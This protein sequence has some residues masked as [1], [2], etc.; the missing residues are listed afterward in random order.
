[1]STSRLGRL[2]LVGAILGTAE[3]FPVVAQDGLPQERAIESNQANAWL[4]SLESQLRAQ[5]GAA[6]GVRGLR[7]GDP[8]SGAAESRG[9]GPKP[10]RRHGPFAAGAGSPRAPGGGDRAAAAGAEAGPGGGRQALRDPQCPATD[11]LRFRRPD[12][13]RSRLQPR[14]CDAGRRASPCLFGHAALRSGMRRGAWARGAGRDMEPPAR[15]RELIC[16][17]GSGSAPKANAWKRSRSGVINRGTYWGA[18]AESMPP[19]RGGGVCPRGERHLA[20]SGPPGPARGSG[21]TGDQAEERAFV[22]ATS[23]RSRCA[24]RRS[25]AVWRRGPGRGRARRSLPQ[26]GAERGGSPT[27]RL[28]RGAEPRPQQQLNQAPPEPRDR[29]ATPPLEVDVVRRVRRG[30]PGQAGSVEDSAPT[31]EAADGHQPREGR[32]GTKPWPAASQPAPPGAWAVRR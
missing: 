16:C 9:S 26:R 20:R 19:G 11:R 7:G 25:L 4:S 31:A 6:A 24:S 18:C 23:W 15:R 8:R 5:G 30:R 27:V 32:Y 14:S 2:A 3:A 28:R 13:D 17:R 29:A 21:A 1:M 10:V 22:A 12:P